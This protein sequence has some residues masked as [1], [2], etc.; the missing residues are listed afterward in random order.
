MKKELDQDVAK[1]LLAK[2]SELQSQIIILQGQ[3]NMLSA[4]VS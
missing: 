3:L 4:R 2:I 1:M